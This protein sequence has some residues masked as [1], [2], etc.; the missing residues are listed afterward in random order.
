MLALVLV[1]TQAAIAHG[2]LQQLLRWSDRVELE[3]QHAGRGNL[4]APPVLRELSR[5]PGLVTLQLAL[6]ITPLEARQLRTLKRF[7]ART[8]RP[9]D[10]SLK[11]LAPALVRILP[12]PLVAAPLGCRDAAEDAVLLER[13]ADACAL[14]WL[15]QRL[16]LHPG[17]LE[18]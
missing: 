6:P 2:D 11:L 13:G 16:A 4:L 1:L 15:S 14:Q 12:E 7:A 8:A 17:P 3:V 9:R 10:P 18:K 5:W